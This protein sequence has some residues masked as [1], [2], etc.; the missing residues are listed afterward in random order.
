MS[1]L[2]IRGI[3]DLVTLR[4]SFLKKY[5][6]ECQLCHETFTLQLSS[7]TNSGTNTTPRGHGSGDNH[8]LLRIGDEITHSAA[9][10]KV[11]SISQTSGVNS[12]CDLSNNAT[13]TITQNTVVTFKYNY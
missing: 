10:T 5:T 8:Q 6:A 7:D 13:S 3:Q 11:T 2:D 9:N 4:P 1:Q 12:S